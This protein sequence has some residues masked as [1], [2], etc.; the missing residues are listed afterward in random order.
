LPEVK[1]L[2]PVYFVALR[3]NDSTRQLVGSNFTGLSTKPE[4]IDWAKI[5]LVDDSDRILC[6]LH[7]SRQLT[8]VKLKVKEKPGKK[9]TTRSL[10]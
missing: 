2:S 9:A 6:R 8:K 7:S 3:L 1:E 4:T 10:G 5:H